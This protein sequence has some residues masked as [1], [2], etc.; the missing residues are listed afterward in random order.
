MGPE[1]RKLGRL[2]Y[3]EAWRLQQELLAR[4]IQGL[5]D[6]ILLV[7][8][9]DPV[10]TFGRK[11]PGVRELEESKVSTW[12]GLPLFI[13]E[14]GGEATYHGPGQIVIYPIFRLPEK[15]GPRG[16]LR[17]LEMATINFLREL[18]REAF[19][20]TG[21]T[22]VWV[23]DDKGRERKIASIGIAARSLVSYHGLALNV[24]ASLEHFRL[25]KPCGFE[26]DVMCNLED[27]L[28]LQNHS[29]ANLESRLAECVIQEFW[30]A[31]ESPRYAIS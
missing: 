25:I 20:R 11:F 1:I 31:C 13:V 4:R 28:E 14:R 17:V 30:R 27:I 24:A 19:V 15:L 6:D 7:V 2:E 18:G 12:N 23:Y 8:E 21:A 16:M 22:G 9:H 3:Q 29:L 26:P 5:I 10:I